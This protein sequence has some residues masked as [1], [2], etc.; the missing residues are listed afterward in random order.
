MTSKRNDLTNQRFGRLIAHHIDP[1]SSGRT[2]WVCG[3]DCG[4]V[5]SV[6]R[7]NLV[8]G[9]SNSCGC[10]KGT[11]GHSR[12]GRRSLTM[13]SWAAMMQRCTI[14]NSPAF[15]HYKNRGISVCDRWRAGEDGLSG[16][17]C[18]LADV[19]ERPSL[20]HT[21]ERVDNDKGYFPGNC[22]W[23]TMKAQG[24]NRITTHLFLHD[25]KEKTLDEL[26]SDTG[27]TVDAL[28][29]R[30][31]RKRMPLDQ[32]LALPVQ[33]GTRFSRAVPL[34]LIEFKGERLTLRQI[35]ER[36]GLSLPT[37]RGR[38]K[39]NRPLVS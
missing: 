5:V 10:A 31:V 1:S 33:K 21:L 23:A 6:D 9:N 28:R 3:C 34:T 12:H 8:G 19:G 30:L 37:L 18:F 36:T 39:H 22:E 16:F 4:A 13:S 27:L 38:H 35:S 2:K 7:S 20:R 15:E 14:P 25:G 24:R 29:W 11:H 26:A 32:A 17:S